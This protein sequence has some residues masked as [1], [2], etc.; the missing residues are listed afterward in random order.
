[1][2]TKRHIAKDPMYDPTKNFDFWGMSTLVCDQIAHRTPHDHLYN[3][4]NSPLRGSSGRVS[5]TNS[6][7]LKGA[8]IAI[9]KVIRVRV[10]IAHGTFH[11]H[12]YN[13]N[14]NC[15][16]LVLWIKRI[17]SFQQPSEIIDNYEISIIYVKLKI[18]N[19]QL[20]S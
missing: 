8:S 18:F 15:S 10:Y 2:H 16:R 3:I 11:D 7:V 12:L 4:N 20:S 17:S 19:F 14:N 13:T 6:T 9:I 1:M 5:L